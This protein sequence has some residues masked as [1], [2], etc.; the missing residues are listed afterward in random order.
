[1]SKNTLIPLLLFILLQLNIYGQEK[2]LTGKVVNRETLMPV[3]GTT[4]KIT[5][6]NSIIYQTISDSSGIFNIDAFFLKQ[7]S[8]INFHTL[9]YDDIQLDEVQINKLVKKKQ[10][11]LGV[12]YLNF[13]SILINEIKIKSHARYRDTSIIDLSKKKFDRSIMI[14]D[15]LSNGYG[16]YIDAKGSLYYNGKLVSDLVVNGR[17]FFGKNNLEIYNLLPALVLQNI[18]IIETNIDSTLNTTMLRPTIKI[19]LSFKEQYKKGK[20]GNINLGAGTFNRY[21]G[22]SNLYHYNNNEQISLSVVANNINIGDNSP[23]DPT[24]S[25]SANSN[26]TNSKSASMSYTNTFLKKI[27]INLKAKA[28][29]TNSNYSS[30]LERKDEVIK[31]LSK[32]TNKTKNKVFGMPES[33]L[34]IKYNIDSLNTL[35][36]NQVYNFNKTT[37]VDSL[38]YQINSDLINS[39]ANLGRF[40]NRYISSLNI[41]GIF[42]HRFRA[43]KGR[44]FDIKINRENKKITNTELDNFHNILN[45]TT[46]SY[47]VKSTK[48]IEDNFLNFKINF[49]EPISKNSYLELF[50]VYKK[51][52]I[53]Y[54]NSLKSDTMVNAPNIPVI[55][56]NQFIESGVHF[57]KTFKKISFDFLITELFDYRTNHLIDQRNDANFFNLNI[58]ANI[59]YR[60]NDKKT[61][62]IE[63]KRNTIY[64]GLD[65]LTDINNSF[66]LLYQTRGNINLKPQVD[67]SLKISYFS[68]MI[69]S[70]DLSLYAAINNYSDKFGLNINIIPNFIQTAFIDNIGNSTSGSV[71]AFIKTDIVE[72]LHVSYNSNVA[73]QQ[74]PTIINKQL[75]LNSGLNF[76]QQLF[77]TKEIIKNKLSISPTLTYLLSK[78]YY[79][80]SSS[81]ITNLTY[82]DKFSFSLIKLAF[83]LYPLF[84]YSH[85][86]SAVTNFSMNG[87]VKKHFFKNNGAIWIQA[88]DIFNSFKYNNNFNG[89]YYTSSIKYSNVKRYFI[90]GCGFK[91]NNMK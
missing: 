76:T 47:F 84:N 31:Q 90:I 15:L 42:I 43:K 37:S 67:N 80:S 13:K 46:K 29:L 3:S 16:F 91:F 74:L 30:E 52:E 59:D 25:F 32:I 53:N 85:N 2:Y 8:L 14:N 4:I 26:N 33:S 58:N 68:K 12:F 51:N 35:T 87:A 79:Q 66:D 11:N 36:L 55:I 34:T 27:E 44:T 57:Q 54:K 20:F 88:Y 86:I 22:N 1:M 50:S 49:T 69:N 38:N 9:N 41:E 5:K 81:T 6:K 83:E 23:I 24:I 10:D 61:F 40:T 56:S 72:N 64:P 89:S 73:Y 45:D 7:G 70:I 21:L 19:D 48:N 63:L 62:L 18:K 28:K 39:T 65:N 82:S 60:I 75:N 17:V 77:T 71:G 78:N